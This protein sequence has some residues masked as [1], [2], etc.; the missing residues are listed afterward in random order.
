MTRLLAKAPLRSRSLLLSPTIRPA[1]IHMLHR[2]HLGS[3][4]HSA[5][6]AVRR[7]LTVRRGSTAVAPGRLLRRVPCTLCRLGRDAG[8]GMRR[9]SAVLG[10]GRDD[11]LRVRP[12]LLLH[13]VGVHL[14]RVPAR[15]VRRVGVGMRGR[16]AHLVRA[17]RMGTEVRSGSAWRTGEVSMRAVRRR[18]RVVRILTDRLEHTKDQFLISRLPRQ[19]RVGGDLPVGSRSLWRS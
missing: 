4:A 1:R 3:C 13:P 12:L 10:D 5:G 7:W 14:R 6:T 17:G 16:V 19:I 11:R 8:K 18:W 9:A 15:E 2:S